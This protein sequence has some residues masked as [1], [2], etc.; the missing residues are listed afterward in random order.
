MPELCSD[1]DSDSCCDTTDSSDHD[2]EHDDL[3][4]ILRY[5]LVNGPYSRRLPRSTERAASMHE[6]L[7]LLTRIGPGTMDVMEII[8]GEGRCSKIAIRRRL[9]VGKNVDIVTGSDLRLPSEHALL[10][11]YVATCRPAVVIMAPLCTPFGPLGRF[12]ERI[13]YEG[14]YRSYEDGVALAFICGQIA[15]DQIRNGRHFLCEDPHPTDL[16]SIHPWPL[17]VCRPDA[18]YAVIHQL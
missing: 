5:M 2:P 1:I 14:W 17:V 8:G 12:N 6:L 18:I 7:V 10:R 3:D 9:S 11:K 15:L 4:S 16:H 13:H